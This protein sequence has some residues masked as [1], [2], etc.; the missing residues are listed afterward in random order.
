[1]AIFK[2]GDGAEIFYSLE[3][4]GRTIVLIHGWS[5]DS[6][7]FYML[8]RLLRRDFR[9]LTYDLR[10]H[11]QS[12]RVDYGLTMRRYA[13]DLRELMDYLGLEEPS[14]VGWS[15]GASIVLEYLE[16]YSD[17]GLG[18][19]FFLDMSPRL[20]NDGDWK[21]G[22]FHGAYGLEDG[23]EDLTRINESWP[24]FARDFLL[25]ALPYLDGA[26][27]ALALEAARENTVQVM[28]A[29][30]LA[31]IR[32]DYRPGL[33]DIGA[34]SYVIYGEESQLYSRETAL[35]FKEALGDGQ[36]IGLEGLGHF[37]VV[38]GAERLAEII[39]VL[40]ASLA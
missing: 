2:A 8:A 23:L 28:S 15:L 9:V 16:L 22:L 3:G 24:D 35:Y 5:A 20:V 40:V 14:L 18:A 25:K 29:L 37:L 19:L 27:L 11:G 13:Q 36:L 7:S 4:E 32:A 26:D 39:K 38:E 21:L 1:M 30:W 6:R 10:G 17:Q 33:G 12:E 31:L 34:R